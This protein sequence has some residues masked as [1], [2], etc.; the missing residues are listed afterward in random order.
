M[1]RFL[2]TQVQ[3]IAQNVSFLEPRGFEASFITLE[4]SFTDSKRYFFPSCRRK[5]A[6]IFFCFEI[7]AQS[8][9]VVINALL[10]DYWSKK[11][12]F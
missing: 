10:L 4:A 6:Y 11:L 8:S 1:D 12:K 9:L 7:N 2:K 5:R 3:L